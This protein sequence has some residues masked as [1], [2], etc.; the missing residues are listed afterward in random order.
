MNQKLNRREFIRSTSVLPLCAVAGA[1]LSGL[2]A[3]AAE[4]TV[5]PA[6]GQLK[7]AL[8]AYSFNRLLNDSIKNRGGGVTLLQ[9]LDFCAKQQFDGFDP[10]GY[11]FPGYPNVPTDEYLK[12]F[13]R[14]AADLGLGIIGPGV[15]HNFT[16][17]DTA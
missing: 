14:R 5:K 2:T 7:T 1:G 13:K 10:T 3:F 12:E 9:V 8:N 16:S 4:A 17:S 11:F 15:R 6:A